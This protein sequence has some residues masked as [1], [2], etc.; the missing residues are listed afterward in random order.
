V[1]EKWLIPPL[2]IVAVA[3]KIESQLAIAGQH[4][5]FSVTTKH[6]KSRSVRGATILSPR[7]GILIVSITAA[8]VLYFQQELD[9][10][11]RRRESDEVGAFSMEIID[12]G[13]KGAASSPAFRCRQHPSSV[14]IRF[15]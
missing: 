5:R 15:A 11:P 4:D 12:S 3:Q 10:K 13:L 1:S 6:E 14:H 2:R 7:L 8:A 9:E